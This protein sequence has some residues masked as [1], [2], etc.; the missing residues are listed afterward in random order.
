ML[1]LRSVEEAWASVP[2]ASAYASKVDIVLNPSAS[3]FALGKYRYRWQLVANSSRA[4]NAYYLYSNS[5]GLESGRLIYDGGVLLACRG[6]IIGAGKRFSFSEADIFL[7]DIDIDLIR[8]NKLAKSAYSSF[9]EHEKKMDECFSVQAREFLETS[10]GD[11][12][13]DSVEKLCKD[14]AWD[15]NSEFLLAEALGLFDYLRKTSAKGFV[16]SLSGGC[17][18]ATVAVLVAHMFAIA[19]K[20]LKS[21]KLAEKLRCKNW[22]EDPREW[23]K[24][25]LT[26]VYQK[27]KNS[28]IVTETA[29]QSL[30]KELCAEYHSINIQTIVDDYTQMIEKSMNLKVDWGTH[31]LVLQN[32]QARAR[33]PLAWMIANI[34]EAIL[35]ATSNRSEAAVGYATMDG[36]TAG[37]YSPISGIDKFFLRKWLN[38]SEHDCNLGL[39][40]LPVLK[41]IN[42]QEPTAELRPQELQQTDENDLMPYAVLASIERRIVGEKESTL[43]VIQALSLEFPNYTE[44]EHR[45]FLNRFMTKWRRNQWKRERIAPSFHI[46]SFSLDPKSWCRFPILTG[47]WE[48]ETVQ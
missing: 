27:T 46:D 28:S 48:Q 23:V 20:E 11:I 15:K 13:Q 38:W 7:S 41:L 44:A 4:M 31:D 5:V 17:D 25:Y 40:P 14:E 29:A 37:G 33:A 36:D 21:E 22:G 6:D 35:L 43:E 9:S 24:A 8:T 16:V 1:L 34:K 47:D 39:G 32:I 18:S 42:V 26:C 45:L 3:H 12:S 19:L 30:A 2:A 10:I